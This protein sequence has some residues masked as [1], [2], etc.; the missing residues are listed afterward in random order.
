M[1]PHIP[2]ISVRQPW[3]SLITSGA[4]TIETRPKPTKHRGWIAIHAAASTVGW[5]Q[6]GLSSWRRD[7]DPGPWHDMFAADPDQVPGIRLSTSDDG[8]HWQAS[9]DPKVWPLGAVVGT[10]R[11]V[12]CVPIIGAT[13]GVEQAWMPHIAEAHDWASL[14]HWKG[15]DRSRPENLSTGLHLWETADIAG[16]LPLGDFTPGRWAYLLE[17][18]K[19]TTERCPVCLGR[20]FVQQSNGL[21]GAWGEDG[22]GSWSD[23]PHC[24]QSAASTMP[25]GKSNP[26]PAKGQ[27]SVPWRWRP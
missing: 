15:Q 20:G 6:A 22:L 26:I 3:A 9:A 5:R 13:D 25:S 19:P 24:W 12:D 16:Q 11:I 23:C 8:E 1:T 27:Q 18:A 7:T 4:K 14:L 21:G 17:D 10:A 2:A